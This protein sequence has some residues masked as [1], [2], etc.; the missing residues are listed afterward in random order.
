MP[1]F[2]YRC[3][4]TGFHVQGYTLG[5]TS[6]EN[7][8]AYEAVICVACNGVHLVNATT[9]KVMGDR[10]FRDASSRVSSLAAERRPGS[11]SK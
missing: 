3:P 10:G 8:P 1:A 5:R 2:L 4:N 9:S 7:D 6:N 11:S